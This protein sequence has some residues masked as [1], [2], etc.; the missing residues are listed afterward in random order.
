MGWL[1]GSGKRSPQIKRRI[2][3]L[4]PSDLFARLHE[5]PRAR[6]RVVVVEPGRG[7]HP[8]C[9]EIERRERDLAQVT[10]HD[11]LVPGQ[12][13][14]GVLEVQVVLICPEPRNLRERLALTG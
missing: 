2:S 13:P 1:Q 6:H 9:A 5:T 7:D 3:Q 12:S 11:D 14:T 8:T 10:A 4:Q